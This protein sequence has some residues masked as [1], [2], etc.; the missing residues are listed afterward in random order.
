MRN[1]KSLAFSRAVGSGSFV[2]SSGGDLSSLLFVMEF[3]GSNSF[4][5]G[6]FNVSKPLFSVLVRFAAHFAVKGPSFS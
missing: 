3:G 4:S 1:E 5:G 2:L 6:E